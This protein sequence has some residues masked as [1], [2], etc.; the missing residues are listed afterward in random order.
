LVLDLVRDEL[1]A[2]TVQK[3]ALDA[4]RAFADPSLLPLLLALKP[5][6]DLAPDLLERAIR[7]CTT[8][9]QED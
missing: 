8:G 5:R 7:T 3:L 6:W 4:A 2:N 9:E 1:Q